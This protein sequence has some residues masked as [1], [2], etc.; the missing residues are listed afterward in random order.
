MAGIGVVL[1]LKR[2]LKTAMIKCEKRPD[3]TFDSVACY[4]VKF[5]LSEW[6]AEKG[7]IN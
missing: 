3:L 6:K 1:N 2:T 4:L 7:E 5:I